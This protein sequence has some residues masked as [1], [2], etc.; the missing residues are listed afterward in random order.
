[1]TPTILTKDG[2][3][4][5]VVGSPGGSTIITSVYQTILNVTD[6]GMTM[7]EA[8]NAKRIHHQWR[9]DT[10]Q[11][12]AEA[13]DSLTA[14]RLLGMGHFLEKYSKIGRVDA[15]LVRPDKKFEGGADPRGDDTAKGF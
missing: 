10:I 8:V 11:Y 7:Q 6:Y 12:E 15:I 13:F 1:M 3:L 2:E 9:P 14:V 5:M 4:F